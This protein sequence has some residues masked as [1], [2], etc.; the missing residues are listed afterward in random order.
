MNPSTAGSYS[1]GV[2][3]EA[4]N[5]FPPTQVPTTTFYI[6]P[7]DLKPAQTQEFSLTTEYQIAHASTI[8]VGYVGILGHHLTAAQVTLVTVEGTALYG[9]AD[10]LA[11]LAPERPAERIE[12]CG[13]PKALLFSGKHGDV[14]A[15]DETWAHTAATLTVAL[16]HFGRNLAP[17]AECGQ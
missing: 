13:S 12:V 7:K 6:W 11:K 8:Q 14:D 16:G 3:Y 9:D 1:P 15:S 4:S 10:L 2:F 5:G 17:L